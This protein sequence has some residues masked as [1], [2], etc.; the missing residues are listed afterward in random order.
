[1]KSALFTYQLL[2][3]PQDSSQI[4]EIFASDERLILTLNTVDDPD[5]K[6]R[7]EVTILVRNDSI[8]AINHLNDQI[9]LLTH[10]TNTVCELIPR[11]KVVNSD[12]QG[13]G[14]LTVLHDE[15]IYVMTSESTGFNAC[16]GQ[17]KKRFYAL[18]LDHQLDPTQTE[19]GKLST[20][21]LVN[22]SLARSRL[23]FG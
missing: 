23:L 1:S 4:K 5:F 13:A 7:S 20:L 18:P 12:S 14:S 10:F 17:G 3:N 22:E 15:L 21:E 9:R 16:E 6:G 8:Y 11:E 2:E 19:D